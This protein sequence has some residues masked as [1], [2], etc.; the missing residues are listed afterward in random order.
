MVV[1]TDSMDNAT[2][3][4][5]LR[6]RGRQYDSAGNPTGP[7]FIVP[8]RNLP[9]ALVSI[10]SNGNHYFLSWLD[11]RYDN[12]TA[13]VYAKVVGDAIIAIEPAFRPDLGFLLEPNYPNPFNPS[14]SI[15]FILPEA[16]EVRLEVFSVTGQRVDVVT[17]GY[18]PAG[19]HAVTWSA[20]RQPS[21]IYFCRLTAAGPSGTVTATRR[22]V[23]VK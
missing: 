2:G 6:A 3:I 14:T 8:D 15:A 4:A 20:T 22:M 23:M 9:S 11:T 1:W 10:A 19:R 16:G 21:G 12:V 7:P 18:L 5:A 13:N 17:A